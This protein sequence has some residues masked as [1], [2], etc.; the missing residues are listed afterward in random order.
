[1][2]CCDCFFLG[3]AGW[4]G[5]KVC[6][7]WVGLHVTAEKIK[8]YSYFH[9]VKNAYPQDDPKCQTNLS[10]YTVEFI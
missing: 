3:G 10:A 7:R 1:M 9:I 4:V 6:T 5:G 8:I 2:F